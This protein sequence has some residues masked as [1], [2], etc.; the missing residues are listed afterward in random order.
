MSPLEGDEEDVKSEPEET[1]GERLKL[2]SRK[3]KKQEPD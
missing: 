1:A 3:R 2:N